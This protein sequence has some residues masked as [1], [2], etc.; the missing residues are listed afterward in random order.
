MRIGI[1]DLGTNSVRFDVQS[2]GLKGN[3]RLLHREKL[4]IRLGQNVFLENKLDPD[5]IHRTVQA[6]MSFK[7]T[8]ASLHVTKIVAFGTSAL[9]EASDAMYLVDL[10]RRKTQ[11][12]IRVISGEEE[13]HLIATGILANEKQIRGYFGLIDIGGG[14]TEINICRGKKVLHS[15]SF[16]VGVA[17]LQQMFMDGHT[18]N[19]SGLKK[20]VKNVLDLKIESENWPKVSRMIGSSGT[21]RA[22]QKM[23]KKSVNENTLTRRGLTKLV[24][25]MT[26]LSRAELLSLPGIETKRVDLILSGALLLETCMKVFDTKTLRTTNFALRDGILEKEI[27]LLSHQRENEIQFQLKDVQEKAT[28]LG[29]NK[30]HSQQVATLA[31]NLFDRTERLHKLEKKWKR[32]LIAAALLHDVGDSVTPIHHEIHSYYIAK[33]LDLLAMENWE[34]EFI[35]QLCLQHNSRIVNKR[36]LNFTKDKARRQVFVRL[37]ALLQVADAL[38]RG[39]KARIQIRSVS[40]SENSVKIRISGKHATDLEILRVEQKRALFEK[41]FHKQ[42]IVQGTEP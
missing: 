2:I 10:I 12:D 23:L 27:R 25:T 26:P 24:K 19:P 5:A 38:D 29:C 14:S 28:R 39:H 42:L 30:S 21:T 4:M 17:R 31:E 9:R 37:L 1:I 41:T 33:N 40:F 35:A 16:P 13:A 22:L 20:Y 36:N 15:A 11:I 18:A 6:F 8:G 34:S 7:R 32:Y 3:T